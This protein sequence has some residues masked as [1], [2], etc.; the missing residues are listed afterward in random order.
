MLA[1]LLLWLITP[2]SWSVRINGL[3]GES[4]ALLARYRRCRNFWIPHLL[5]SRRAVRTFLR[6]FPTPKG[7]TTLLGSG[8]GL[9]WSLPALAAAADQAALIDLVHPWAIRCRVRRYPH[10]ALIVADCNQFPLPIP[11][12]TTA[13]LSLNLLSQL[14]LFASH[15]RHS[16]ADPALLVARHWHTLATASIPA[17]LITDTAAEW[18]I[19]PQRRAPPSLPTLPLDPLHPPSAFIAAFR[20]HQPKSATFLP[21]SSP[22]ESLGWRCI[23]CESTLFDFTPPIPPRLTWTWTLAPPGEL[24]ARLIKRLRVGVWL[25]SP[26]L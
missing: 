11:S 6:L 26:P 12:S 23:A 15:R 3:L 19:W 5:N 21:S 22:L 4:V 13:L 18:W 7:T 14:P 20:A 9:E 24:A 16:S 8:H 10:I 25:F 1:E 17:L 2:A